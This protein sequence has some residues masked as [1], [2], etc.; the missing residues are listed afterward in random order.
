MDDRK[1]KYDTFPNDDEYRNSPAEIDRSMYEAQYARCP[2]YY[3]YMNQHGYVDQAQ[4]V[5]ANQPIGKNQN[6]FPNAGFQPTGN[7]N[8]NSNPNF[9]VSAGQFSNPNFAGQGPPPL[10]NRQGNTENHM[11]QQFLT[12][13]GQVDIQKMLQTISQFADTVQ[14]VS[15]VI[16]QINDLVKSFRA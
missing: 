14:Q 16:K 8:P 7:P 10:S 3:C 4:P 5:F 12:E 15:P 11:M 13:D 2:C 9:S 6:G 1:F